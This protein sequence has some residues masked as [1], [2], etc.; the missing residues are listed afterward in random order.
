[1]TTENDRGSSTEP[2]RCAIYARTGALTAREDSADE[3]IQRCREAAQKK[4]WTVIEEFVRIDRGGSGTSMKDRTGLQELITLAATTPRPFDYLICVSTDRLTRN[5]GIAGQIVDAFI[6][7][8][9]NL[10]FV[11]N[12]LDSADP[13]FRAIFNCVAESDLVYSKCFAD[14]VRR[15][16]IGRFLSGYHP[17][18]RC[19]GYTNVPVEDPD[20]HWEGGRTVVIGIR[21]VKCDSEAEVVERIFEG[22]A[23]G[24]SLAAIAT[25]LN[26]DGVPPPQG[27]AAG[28][29]N[30]SPSAIS[31]ILENQ[32][33]VGRTRWNK[34]CVTRIPATGK[35][36]GKTR[37]KD[38][39]LTMEKPELRLI[40]D[41]LFERVRELRH[42]GKSR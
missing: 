42:R 7:H 10:Y 32:R 35:L 18:G 38:E 27:R 3:Q 41:N 39:W 17:G 14:K 33:Y 6:H 20:R 1:M 4:G 28:T 8:G 26:A 11:F 13:S 25:Q 15:G 40:S 24:L 9:V 36:E 31:R 29:P 30:W 2:I 5:M 37:P 22:F 16:K 34:R 21:Q 23:S 19:F 12:R